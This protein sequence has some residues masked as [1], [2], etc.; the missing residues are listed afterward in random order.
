VRVVTPFGAKAERSDFEALYVQ[1]V[2]RAVSESTE[3]DVV[4]SEYN[5]LF[6]LDVTLP[7]DVRRADVDQTVTRVS[8]ALATR[9]Q[10]LE[11]I[12]VR[13]YVHVLSGRAH[14]RSLDEKVRTVPAHTP[15]E[16]NLSA[17]QPVR[18]QYSGK[19]VDPN[20][21][22]EVAEAAALIG[23]TN[24]TN[25]YR[26]L[27]LAIEE[28]DERVTP[29]TITGPIRVQGSYIIERFGDYKPRRRK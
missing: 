7:F 8:D 17:Q 26:P 18:M 10:P 4:G 3:Y 16:A 13:S 5:G 14:T 27:Q 20:K 15:S 28:G 21:E 25:L 1:A 6:A 29:K 19:L 9:A 12:G 24:S 22:Y 11:N 23:M 2:V